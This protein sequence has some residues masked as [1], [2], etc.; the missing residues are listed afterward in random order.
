MCSYTQCVILHTVCNF[1][2]NVPWTDTLVGGTGSC[3]LY[4]IVKNYQQLSKIIK[5]C[6]TLA[7]NVQNCPKLLKIVKIVKNC[8]N[9]PKLQNNVNIV[10]N[11]L[12]C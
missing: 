10:Q 12:H 1:K 2:H 3:L 4:C 8:Q 9:C 6:Q 11:C 7:N 5:N